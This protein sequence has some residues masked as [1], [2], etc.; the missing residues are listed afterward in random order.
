MS[1]P[2][3]QRAALRR[4]ARQDP[5]LAARLVVM[6]LPAAA[7]AIRD[8]LAYRL[9]VEEIGDYRVAVADG[10]ARV[11][12]AGEDDEPVDF[13]L[14]TDARTLVD[15]ALGEAKPLGL[16]LRGRLRIR[17]KRRRVL[18]LRAMG[19]ASLT[20]WEVVEAGGTLDPDVLYRSLAHLI[21]PR[22]T[23]G[24]SFT[25]RYEITADRPGQ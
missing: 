16:M 3:A 19:S 20:L 6:T 18:K 11:D 9:S 17:G 7:S 10:G 15:M 1:A 2:Y 14:V 13:R 23:K 4:I 22:W 5:E 25:V 21:D 8:T 24:H 12:P